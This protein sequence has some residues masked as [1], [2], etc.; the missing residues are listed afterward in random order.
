MM[1]VV[2]C[3]RLLQGFIANKLVLA[4]CWAIIGSTVSFGIHSLNSFMAR[5]AGIKIPASGSLLGLALGIGLGMLVSLVS[6]MAYYGVYKPAIVG[7]TVS[8]IGERLP[9]SAIASISSALIEETAFRGGVVHFAA[10]YWGQTVGLLC[11]S[12]PF[13][14]LHLSNRFWGIPVN[15]MHVLGTAMSGLLLSAVYLRWGLLSAIGLHWVWNS[16]CAV[17]IPLFCP[18]TGGVV[19]FEGSPTTTLILAMASAAVL[20]FKT[21]GKPRESLPS[22]RVEG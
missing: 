22:G 19:Q 12:L 17:W 13:G 18:G 4:T 20:L 6:G 16:L 21:T 9:L 14:L 1:I 7:T 3:G 11:G 8:H 10:G 15:L 5:K 2:F